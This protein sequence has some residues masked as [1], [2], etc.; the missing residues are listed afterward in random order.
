MIVCLYNPKRPEKNGICGAGSGYSDEIPQ[1]GHT[2]RSGA[3]CGK[4]RREFF[5]YDTRADKGSAAGYVLCC[6]DREFCDLCDERKNDNN[7]EDMKRNMNRS[8]K[9]GTK[10]KQ[11]GSSS[12]GNRQTTG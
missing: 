2:C 10:K 11:T 6:F 8:I 7:Q 1:S 9:I 5:S 12:D 4:G 3:S